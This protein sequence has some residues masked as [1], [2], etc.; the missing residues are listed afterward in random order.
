VTVVNR[1]PAGGVVLVRGAEVGTTERLATSPGELLMSGSRPTQREA[2][3]YKLLSIAI[4]LALGVAP[5]AAA[6]FTIGAKGGANFS[7]LSVTENG[8][9]PE[10]PYG[11][12]KGLLLGATAGLSVAPWLAFQ[13][14][15]RYSQEGTQQ[16]DDGI[17]ALL[18]LSYVDVPLVARVLIPTGESP[19]RPY[20]FAGGFV[21]FE[22]DCGVKTSG[23]VS[24]EL[25]CETADVGRQSTDYGVVFGAG[26]DVRLGPGAVTLDI[27]YSLGLRNMAAAQN[28]GEAH[29][30]VFAF[31][32]GYKLV[33]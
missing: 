15:G 24:V 28:S 19:V 17:T 27:E 8:G 29:S 21:G 32:A 18:R 12:R 9:D 14:E 6:Q 20:L 3:V 4:V 10:V 23:A 26:T 7:N 25:D 2:A 11:S 31:T 30:R 16:T 13:L 22:T 5:A 33:L 1:D